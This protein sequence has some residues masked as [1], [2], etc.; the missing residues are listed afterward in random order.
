MLSTQQV[1]EASNNSLAII[2]HPNSTE[3]YV[4]KIHYICIRYFEESSG[5]RTKKSKYYF[6]LSCLLAM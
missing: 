5:L 1:R 3:F 4:M 6:Q 2:H